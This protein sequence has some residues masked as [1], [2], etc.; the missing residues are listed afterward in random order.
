MTLLMSLL[1]PEIKKGDHHGDAM[2]G[3]VERSQGLNEST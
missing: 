3:V 1:S 2:D